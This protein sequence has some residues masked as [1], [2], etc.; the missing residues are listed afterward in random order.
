MN[1][2]N[3]TGRI[4]TRALLVNLGTAVVVII[5]ERT[6]RGEFLP[7]S[8]AGG[9]Y[10]TTPSPMPLGALPAR[11]RGKRALAAL[12]ASGE[13]TLFTSM[14]SRRTWIILQGGYKKFRELA[15]RETDRVTLNWTG[16]MMRNL[17]VRHV[18]VREGVVDIGFSEG[19]AA[20]LASY[21][22]TQGAGRSRRVRR[23]IGLTDAELASLHPIVRDAVNMPG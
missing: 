10:S 13:A 20:R 2:L 11:A 19:R 16:Q 6:L 18:S 17:K 7:G 22:N 15:G 21:H 5:K 23:F 1:E 12:V 14:R 9:Q 4:V 8:T 3:I